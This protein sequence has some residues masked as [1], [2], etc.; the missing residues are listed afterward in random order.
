M[1][2]FE[3]HNRVFWKMFRSK[4]GNNSEVMDIV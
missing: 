3:H 4:R 2:L 1:M